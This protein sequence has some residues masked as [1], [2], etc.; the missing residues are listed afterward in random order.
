MTS[1]SSTG[2]PAYIYDEGSDTWHPIAQYQHSH[3]FY[4]PSGPTGPTGPIGATGPTGAT[5]QQ[6]GTD[7]AFM[8]MGV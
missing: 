1:I 3:E 6:G 4:G 8:L 2:R 7:L 5:G